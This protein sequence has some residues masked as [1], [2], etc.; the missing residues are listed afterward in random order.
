MVS[1]ILLRYRRKMFE[2][3]APSSSAS[4][5]A[6]LASS[7]ACL[8]LLTLLLPYRSPSFSWGQ[9]CYCL[10][11]LTESV[12]LPRTVWLL[13][14]RWQTSSLL[15]V[16]VLISPHWSLLWP[17]SHL[18][19]QAHPYPHFWS[20]LPALHVSFFSFSFHCV[21]TGD[22]ASK[23]KQWQKVGDVTPIRIAISKMTKK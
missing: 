3:Q 22:K 16:L 5:S 19:C 10:S 1:K 17:P 6:P 21:A 23:G 14:C 9:G 4:P 15:Q 8:L 2:D 13:R 12:P 7:P 11:V 18:T 20:I